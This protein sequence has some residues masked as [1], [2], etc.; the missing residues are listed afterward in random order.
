MHIVHGGVVE[1]KRNAH[2]QNEEQEGR[3]EVDSM[4]QE[5]DSRT[6]SMGGES[7]REQR[8][9]NHR[10][11]LVS[12]S[13]CSL[14]VPD[15]LAGI[16]IDYAEVPFTISVDN[17]DY[18]DESGIDIEK[19][20]EHIAN[21]RSGGR[22]SCPSPHA[23]LEAW[24]DA[25]NAIAF[26]LSAALS[27]SYNSAIAARHMALEKNPGRNIA[28][29]NTCGAGVFPEQLANIIYEGIEDGDSFDVIVSAADKM[30]REIQVV[31]A[32]G[33]LDNLIKA[34][35]LNKLVGYAAH[36]FNISAIGVASPGGRIELRHKFRGMKKIYG[37]L[38]DTLRETGFTGGELVI[39]HCMNEDGAEKL[40]HLIK[41]EWL[42]ADVSIV[43]ASGL[44]SY[45][46][47]KGGMIITYHE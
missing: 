27:G 35:R 17:T 45:Y 32:L 39:S 42:D 3:L 4:T 37:K 6:Q 16:D 44:C 7:D 14:L 23:W 41:A 43:P 22:T 2:D 9:S 10:W 46:M 21:C 8:K 19:M 20:L 31:F 15:G 13:G 30:A 36:R 47:G 1:M 11:K 34:G 24:G 33:S 12:D 5:V 26:T 38:I 25:E 40:G 29:I 18:I 28:V